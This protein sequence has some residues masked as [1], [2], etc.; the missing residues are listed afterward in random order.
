ML[1]LAFSFLMESNRKTLELCAALIS[2]A[3]ALTLSSIEFGVTTGDKLKHLM[4]R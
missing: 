1:R 4:L 2:A 3:E